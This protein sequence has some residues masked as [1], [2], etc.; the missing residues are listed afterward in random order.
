MG[1]SN[2]RIYEEMRE[3]KDRFEEEAIFYKQ[4]MGIASS[5]E[6]IIGKSAAIKTVIDQMRQVACTDSSVLIMGETGVGK[7]LVAKAIHNLS[8]RRDGP[9]IPV[10]L[11]AFPQ[12]LVASELF[13]HEKGAFTGAHEKNKGRFE[14]A[15]GGTIFLDEIGDLPFN[16]QVKLLRV[17]QDGA[18]ERLGSAKPIQSDFRVIA[19]TNKDLS[20]EVEKG[21]F[22][23]DLYYRLNVFPVHVPSLRERKEDIPLIGHHFVDKFSKK[24]GK[25]IR[26]IPGEEL[27]KL[28]EYH[29]PGNVRELKHLIERAV[30]LSDGSR[31]TF[32]SLLH[33]SAHR[34]TGDASPPFIGRRGAGLHRRFPQRYALEGKRT[35]GGNLDPWVETDNTSFPY[36]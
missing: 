10:N 24:M 8:E 32:S 14:L 12:E 18:F 13:G 15:D 25:G 23:Q 36:K 4:E 6:M 26:R 21:T 34:A 5:P 33:V 22:R 31:I 16:V 19:A 27:K 1:L 11:A 3:R 29:W 17:L 28:M 35:Q 30:I 7:E 20:L 2:I 9:F